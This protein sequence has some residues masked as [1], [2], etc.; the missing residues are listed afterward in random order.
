MSNV[1]DLDAGIETAADPITVVIIANCCFGN[2]SE[3]I[4]GADSSS[5]S[6]AR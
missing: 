6:M 3:E 5:S 4:Y 2:Y 1:F